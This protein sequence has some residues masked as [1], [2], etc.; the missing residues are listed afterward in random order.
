MPA[1]ARLDRLPVQP[2]AQ[3]RREGRRRCIAT[4]DLAAKRLEGDGVEVA[5]RSRQRVVVVSRAPPVASIRR[6]AVDGGLGSLASAPRSKGR[7]PASSS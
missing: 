3:V 2:A 5:L 1:A 6:A 7:Q 4:L